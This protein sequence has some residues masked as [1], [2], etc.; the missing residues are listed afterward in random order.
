MRAAALTVLISAAILGCRDSTGSSGEVVDEVLVP[1][2]AIV[3]GDDTASFEGVS[4]L[5]IEENGYGEIMPGGGG[6]TTRAV[7]MSLDSNDPTTFASLRITFLNDLDFGEY[8]ARTPHALGLGRQFV[9]VYSFRRADGTY[10]TYPITGGIVR[11]SLD[12][13]HMLGSF[14]MTADAVVEQRVSVVERRV[15]SITVTGS[16]R[17]PV[18]GGTRL[19]VE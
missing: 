7:A 5:R 8:A 19:G 3:S 17:V 1:F 6:F 14:T 12:G 11:V 10:V 2:S 4:D 9:A 18:N 16:I 15:S 13:E